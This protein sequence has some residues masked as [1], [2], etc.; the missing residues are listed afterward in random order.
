M[1]QEMLLGVHPLEAGALIVAQVIHGMPM[2]RRM[3][4][5]LANTPIIM[6]RHVHKRAAFQS[7]LVGLDV[8][9]AEQIHSGFLSFHQAIVASRREV[10]ASA[11]NKWL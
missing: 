5:A 11:D 6:R 8:R 7:A 4:N 3:F 10:T 2:R 1:V 9:L